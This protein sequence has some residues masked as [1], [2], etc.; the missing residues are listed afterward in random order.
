[1]NLSEFKYHGSNVKKINKQINLILHM[2]MNEMYEQ[3]VA[4]LQLLLCLILEVFKSG[5]ENPSY[6]PSEK[7]ILHFSFL[8][9]LAI[10]QINIK[11]ARK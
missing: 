10:R 6:D 2:E 11:V 9:N 7:F 8:S 4:L 3:S 1:M 5:N